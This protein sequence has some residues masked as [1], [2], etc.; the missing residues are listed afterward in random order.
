MHAGE[1]EE[2]EEEER[3]GNKIMPNLGRLKFKHLGLVDLDVD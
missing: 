2:E 1:E 3:H